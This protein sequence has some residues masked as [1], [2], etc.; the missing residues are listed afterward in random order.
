MFFAQ[1]SH[2]HQAALLRQPDDLSNCFDP[3]VFQNSRSRK[4][5]SQIFCGIVFNIS[6]GSDRFA[7]HDKFPFRYSAGV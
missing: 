6:L 2:P 1:V 7:L 3:R 4:V 5:Q